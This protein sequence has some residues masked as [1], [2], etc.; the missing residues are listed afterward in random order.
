MQEKSATTNEFGKTLLAAATSVGQ[1]AG[2]AFAAGGAG[3]P[4]VSAEREARI[5]EL[6]CQYADGSYHVDAAAV[7]ARIVDEHLI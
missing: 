7:A 3:L 1:R 5:E 2:T 4:D 6:R